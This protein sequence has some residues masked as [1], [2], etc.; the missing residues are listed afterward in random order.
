LIETWLGVGGAGASLGI[1]GYQPE[2]RRWHRDF[3]APGGGVL[4]LE[5]ERDGAAMVMTG[6]G[7]SADGV[8][9]HRV[10]W[11]PTP[12]GAVEERW[13]TSADAGRSWEVR[14]YGVLHRIS[15]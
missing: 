10:A 5:G 13:Q 8:R 6:K 2:R 12:A 1:I 9:V 11:T 3:L 15:E 4:S 7:Y 14:F